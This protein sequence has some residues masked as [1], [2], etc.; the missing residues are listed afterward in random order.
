MPSYPECLLFQRLS[1]GRCSLGLD[2]R[3]RWVCAWENSDENR[4]ELSR[5]S[6]TLAAPANGDLVRFASSCLPADL[7]GEAESENKRKTAPWLFYFNNAML[8]SLV[9]KRAKGRGRGGGGEG[10]RRRV[11]RSRGKVFSW[12]RC[13]QTVP[14][15]SV[16]WRRSHRLRT[17][18]ALVRVEPMGAAVQ[19][20]KM[21]CWVDWVVIRMDQH[22]FVT[23]QVNGQLRLSQGHTAEADGMRWPCAARDVSLPKMRNDVECKSK[24]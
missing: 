18:V 23:R 19:W 15:L 22:G 6:Q 9:Q 17:P 1:A 24:R 21:S 16:H 10:R 3:G 2:G 20:L 14:G 8:G 11:S 12:A 7:G 13:K 4:G 5:V